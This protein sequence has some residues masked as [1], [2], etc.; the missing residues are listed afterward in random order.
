VCRSDPAEW[1]LR[2][3]SQCRRIPVVVATIDGK[4][5]DLR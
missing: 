2:L 5:S 1:I 4:G 3:V